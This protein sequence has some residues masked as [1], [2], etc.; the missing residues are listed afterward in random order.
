MV[1]WHAWNGLSII[2]FSICSMYLGE[3]ALLEQNK[4]SSC[5][6]SSPQGNLF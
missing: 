2:S 5:E 3:S 4:G 6:S 1:F